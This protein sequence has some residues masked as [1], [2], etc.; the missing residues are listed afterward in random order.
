MRQSIHSLIAASGI[1]FASL[2][3]TSCSGSEKRAK[4]GCEQA[5]END[6]LKNMKIDRTLTKS[7]RAGLNEVVV[8]LPGDLENLNPLTTTSA[9]AGYVYGKIFIGLLDI[10][11]DSFK[12]FPVLVKSR[13]E[14]KLIDEGEYKGGMSMAWEIR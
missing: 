14:V 2:A 10:D 13:P 11:P 3:L 5:A 12:I 1:I 4:S 7:E 8:R 9:Y 6:T